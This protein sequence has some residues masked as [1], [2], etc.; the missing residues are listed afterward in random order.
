MLVLIWSPRS[1]PLTGRTFPSASPLARQLARGLCWM[2]VLLVSEWVRVSVC[3]CMCVCQPALFGTS[4]VPEICWHCSLLAD[5]QLSG[6]PGGPLIIRL[7]RK[8]YSMGQTTALRSSGSVLSHKEIC[9]LCKHVRCLFS[10]ELKQRTTNIQP[11]K[12]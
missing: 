6:F 7:S 8:L 9:D 12:F 1:D 3:V 10:S 11:Q 2:T 5:L 4:W